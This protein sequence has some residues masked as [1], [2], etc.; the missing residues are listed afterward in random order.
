MTVHYSNKHHPDV[1]DPIIFWSSFIFSTSILTQFVHFSDPAMYLCPHLS[2]VSQLRG[3]KVG[4]T[5]YVKGPLKGA[6]QQDRSL[7][8]NGRYDKYV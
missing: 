3:I 2:A 5:E 1:I 7:S 8:P 6:T 4:Q